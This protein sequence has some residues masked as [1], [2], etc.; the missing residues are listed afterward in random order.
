M[1]QPTKQLGLVN[2]AVAAFFF[3]VLAQIAGAQQLSMTVDAK[4][5]GAPISRYLYGFFTELHET[6]NEG[7]YWA[8]MLSDRK[9]FNPVSSKEPPPFTGRRPRAHGVR[10]RPVG[11]DDFVVMDSKQVYV[12]EH[13]PM[14]KLEAAAPHG[15]RQGSLG[16]RNGRKYTGRVILAA[17]PGADVK[18]SLVWGDGAADRQ[19]ISIKGLRK[20]YVT[21]PLSFTAGADNDDARL[22]IIGTGKG[23]FHIG[24]VSLMPADNM[25]GFRADLIEAMRKIGP[26]MFRWPGGNMVSAWDWRDSIGDRDKRPPRL[27]YAWNEVQMN[28]MGIDDYMKLN[29]LLNMEPYICVNAGFGDAYSAAQEVEYTNGSVDTPMGKLRAANGHPEP[30]KVTWWNVGN[31]MW[32]TGQMG[33]MAASQYWVKH[34]MF[35]KAMR[36]VDPTIKF[37]TSGASPVETS[38]SR[39]AF[40]ITGKYVKAFGGPADFTG[41][42][43]ANSSDYMDA[44]AEHIYPSGADLAFDAEK[45]AYVKV[46]EP[47]SL[48]TRKLANGVEAVV[49]AWDIYQERFPQLNMDRYPIALDEWVSEWVSDEHGQRTIG[50]PHFSF[51][52]PLAT[53]MALNVMFRNSKRFILS[54]YTDGPHLLLFNKTDVTVRPLGLM[55]E[56]YRQH[57]GTIPVDITGNSPVPEVK[58]TV[59]VDKGKVPPGSATYPLDAVAALTTDRKALTIAVVNPT[60]SEQEIDLS[61]AGV[62]V[63][64]KGKLW[65]ISG[66]DLTTANEPGK[67]QVVDIV[68]SPLTGMPGRLSVP[69]LSVSVYEIPLR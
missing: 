1:N 29:K 69:K 40:N 15:I 63:Q 26:T 28:D 24:A 12:G 58:G 8:E 65:R 14:V 45:E 46:D 32:N 55:F 33:F 60:E 61:V 59:M 50:D 9:F 5:T 68:E 30:Y 37:V 53:A 52:S 39:A 42:L 21:F 44:A 48:R 17:E 62:S 4:K 51:F 20:D 23:S 19:T 7:G 56:M 41:M 31:E 67:P 36:Q 16:I 6:N 64:D 47:L 34:N 54:A 3:C 35:V 2:F 22:E 13:S 43:L 18:V 11:P 66:D 10:W 25:D 57:F 49:E 27:N 38:Q